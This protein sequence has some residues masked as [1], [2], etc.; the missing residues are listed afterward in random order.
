[1]SKGG[2]FIGQ[3]VNSQ[4]LKLLDKKKIFAYLY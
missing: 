3:L 1:M 4:L 2:H